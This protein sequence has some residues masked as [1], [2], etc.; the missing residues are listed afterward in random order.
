MLQIKVVQLENGLFKDL[1]VNIKAHGERKRAQLLFKFVW[2][3]VKK[4]EFLEFLELPKLAQS[5]VQVFSG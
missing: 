3:R 5:Q 2:K 1:V 4:A